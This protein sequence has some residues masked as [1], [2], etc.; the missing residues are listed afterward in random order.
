MIGFSRCSLAI[1]GSGTELHCREECD[2]KHVKKRMHAPTALVW[3]LSEDK[4][5]IATSLTGALIVGPAAG[6][7]LAYHPLIALAR[8]VQLAG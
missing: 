2:H 6:P 1:S 7:D 8:V 3:L 4:S 5:A